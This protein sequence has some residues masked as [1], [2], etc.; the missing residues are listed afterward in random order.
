[1]ART[2]NFDRQEKLTQAMDLF[3][4]KG[5]AQTS[6]A[7]LVDHLG[8]NR[9]SIYN[10]FGDKQTLYRECLRFYLEHVSFGAQDKLLH[11]EAGIAELKAYLR[12]FIDVQREQKFGCFMQNA[13]L[14]KCLDDDCV[15]QECQRLMAQLQQ[16]F[17][18]VLSHS[19]AKGELSQTLSIKD[20]A[21]FLVL[22]LQGIRVLGKA[23]EYAL[24]DNAY[25]VLEA[26]L[27]SLQ[28]P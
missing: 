22:Q 28:R 16:R 27:T 7:D 18:Q 15:Q 12:G 25:S 21:A 2:C 26:Y 23:G 11:Q 1:M 20:I 13:I 24:L 6:I 3:W 9:F 17:I 8:I 5:F 10:S 4:Q 19:Q 14:E